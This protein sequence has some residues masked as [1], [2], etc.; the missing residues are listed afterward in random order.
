MNSG[1]S[2]LATLSF[3]VIC[4]LL[5]GGL[6][7]YGFIPREVTNTQIQVVPVEKPV[8][9]QVE[10]N[11]TLQ[12]QAA[13]KIL[14]KESKE[15]IALNLATDELSTKDFKKDLVS[16]LNANGQSVEDYKDLSVVVQDSDVS[17]R[18]TNGQVELTLKVT[19]FND[20]DSDAED[21]EK[22]KV[23]VNFDVSDLDEDESYEDAEAELD[24]FELIKFYD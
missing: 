5:L 11:S 22:A 10:K 18:R 16:F 1:N 12:D 2:G 14:L 8:I 4:A 21:A 7:V 23:L 6:F 15:S 20:G 3:A 17:V 19:F 24:G 9:V 13:E